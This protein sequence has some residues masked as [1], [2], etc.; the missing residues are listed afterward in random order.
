MKKLLYLTAVAVAMAAAF[1]GCKKNDDDKVVPRIDALKTEISALVADSTTTLTQAR[2]ALTPALTSPV[3]IRRDIFT[4][5]VLDPS[6]PRE[7]FIDTLDYIIAEY[8][9]LCVLWENQNWGVPNEVTMKAYLALGEQY[10][11]IVAK[12]HAKREEL[13]ELLKK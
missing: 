6:I 7:T 1:A 9:N 2:A 4:K 8:D 13:E 5:M 10:R 11:E 3:N 12:L